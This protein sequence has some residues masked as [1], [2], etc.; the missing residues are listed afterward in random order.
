MEKSLKLSVSQESTIILSTTIYIYAIFRSRSY[1]T[2]PGGE[3]ELGA[4]TPLPLL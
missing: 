4:A 1:A 3:G 2:G